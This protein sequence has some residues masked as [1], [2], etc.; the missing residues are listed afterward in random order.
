MKFRANAAGLAV[1]ALGVVFAAG[2]RQKMA[3]QP[4]YRPLDESD[5]FGDGRSSRPVVEG[6]IARGQLRDDEALYTGKVGAAFVETVPFPVTREVLDRGRERFEIFCSPCHDST[7]SG[8][9]MVVLRGYPRPTSFHVD[10][11]RGARVGYLYDV[12]TN[13]FGRMPSYASQVPP[14]DRWAIVCH[15]RA[16]QLSHQ[17]KAGDLTTD[18]RAK[19]EAAEKKP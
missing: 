9:G 10:R 19:L 7:G 16:L 11:L 12:I 5:F 2:C 4:S 8:G 14:K 3:D 13:G 17:F 1:L 6:T 15:L 18:E